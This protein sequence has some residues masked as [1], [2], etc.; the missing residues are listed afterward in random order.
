MAFRGPEPPTPPDEASKRA[1]LGVD[2]LSVSLNATPFSCRFAFSAL[3]RR[4]IV[5][6]SGKRTEDGFETCE[7]ITA[8]LREFDGLDRSATP[9]GV[10]H[11]GELGIRGWRFGH[12]VPPRGVR[13]AVAPERCRR[14]QRLF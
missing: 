5:A 12:V 9:A 6:G 8:Q 3:I 10:L 14:S 7:V 4:M 13:F 11:G 1:A 2:L